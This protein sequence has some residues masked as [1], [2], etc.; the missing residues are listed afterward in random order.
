MDA[1]VALP[2]HLHC[3]WSLP[4]GDSDYSMRWGLIKATFSRVIKPGE[5]R[6]ASQI[7]RGER[8]IWQRRF[9]EPA[10]GCG[11]VQTASIEVTPL[12]MRLLRRHILRASVGTFITDSPR[13][14]AQAQP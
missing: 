3:V 9:W 8:G 13:R 4:G 11:E 2:D 12:T 1:V 14:A 6:S 5:R 7:K 10:V